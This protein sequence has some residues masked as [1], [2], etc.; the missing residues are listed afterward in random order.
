MPIGNL[1]YPL[2]S[3]IVR[4]WE[5]LFSIGSKVV[6]L[7]ASHYQSALF[8]LLDFDST[9]ELCDAQGHLA[10]I[11]RLQTMRFLQNHVVAFQDFVWGGDGEQMVEYK[12][13]PGFVAKIY[14]E[15]DRWIVLIAL[16]EVKHKGDVADLT[17]E[18]KIRNGF[19]KATEWRQ[20][21]I[22][23][24]TKRVRLAV[25]F[26]NNRLCKRAVLLKRRADQSIPLGNEHF[27]AL[28]DGRL[29]LA[30]EQYRPQRGEIYTLKWEW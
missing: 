3:F 21:E 13:S 29:M 8:E 2:S 30:W 12:V 6:P 25:I 11:H 22:W 17:I 18:R 26:P 5:S 4:E 23:K 16:D 7:L 19:T 14:R 15:A 28:P 1:A 20:T 27:R 9:L 10:V 24:P